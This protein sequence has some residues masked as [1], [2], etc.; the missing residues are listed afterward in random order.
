MALPHCQ[1]VCVGT[2]RGSIPK[3]FLPVGKHRF[4][5]ESVLRRGPEERTVRSG[6]RAESAAR[7]HTAIISGSPAEARMCAIAADRIRGQALIPVRRI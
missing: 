3:K 7:F 4:D 1:A 6:H 5:R 2:A